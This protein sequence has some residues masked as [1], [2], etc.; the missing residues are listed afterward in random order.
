MIQ[1]KLLLQ[2]LQNRTKYGAKT[3]KFEKLYAGLHVIL[4][5]LISTFEGLISLHN[6]RSRQENLLKYI[7]V[8]AG[9]EGIR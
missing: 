7:A 8:V 9:W 4:S 1:S 3:L 5:T 2:K 6:R